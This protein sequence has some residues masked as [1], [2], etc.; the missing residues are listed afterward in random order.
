MAT[1]DL[2]IGGQPV[3]QVLNAAGAAPIVLVCEHASHH[4]PQEFD[5]LGL[6]GAALTSHIAWDPGAFEVARRLADKLDA[7]LV[8][9]T[10]SRLVYDCN[11]PPEAAAAMPAR[12]ERDDIPGNRALGADQRADRVARF[13]RPFEALLARTLSGPHAVPALVTLHSFT[14]TFMGTARQVELGV[15]HDADSRLADAVLAQVSGLEASRNA[16]YGPDD[17]VTHTL[18]RHALPRGLPNV[19]IE[20]RNDLIASPAQC[21]EM[22]DKLGHWL[23]L[24]IDIVRADQ[25]QSV[26][27]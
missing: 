26:R 20:I 17:G 16:P 1:A 22:A 9:S 4:I 13:Y 10:V 3:A 7:P 11:R 12:S 14:P 2:D 5:N 24:G 18:K 21:D 27:P 25:T 8:F 19:M 23:R 15:L 6:S